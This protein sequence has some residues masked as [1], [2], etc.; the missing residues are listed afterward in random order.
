MD[1]WWKYFIPDLRNPQNYQFYQEEDEIKLFLNKKNIS[2]VQNLERF[3]D[4]NPSD[5]WVSTKDPHPNELGHLLLSFNLIS[6]IKKEEILK[7]N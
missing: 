2:Y 4:R 6:Y 7:K 5:Y 1:D 3:L